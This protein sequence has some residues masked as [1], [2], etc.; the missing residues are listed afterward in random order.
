MGRALCAC[1]KYLWI[2]CLLVAG[3]PI[4]AGTQ[5]SEF[6]VNTRYI[7]ENILVAGAGWTADLVASG[8]DEHISSGIR[9]DMSALI[10][11]KLNTA[12]L[13]D[14]AKRLRREFRARTVDRH[15]MRGKTPDT[16]EVVFD[17]KL[18]PARFDVSVPKFAYNSNQGWNGASEATATV[19]HNSFTAGLLSDGDDL[20]ERDT[21]IEARYENSHLGSDNVRFKFEFDDFH[22]LWNP[23]TAAL[24][25]AAI[26]R[27]RE[28]FEP[29]L[30]LAVARPLTVSFG[31]SFERMQ[32]EGPVARVEAANA[33]IAS[34]RLHNRIEDSDNLQEFDAGYDL[35]SG[36]RSLASDYG[37]NRHHF[38][39]RYTWTHGKQ[40]VI[41]D[42]MG[43][44]ITGNA[45]LY[46]VF[47]L[48]NSN[49]LRGWNKYEL[50]PLGG[51]RVLSNS[52]EYRY[53]AFQ[54][55]YDMGTIWSSGEAVVARKSVGF[56]VREGPFSVAVA[57]PLKEGRIDPVLM[58]SM[59]Y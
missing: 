7:V 37:Y 59:N 26:Y 31:V 8:R 13:D 42:A 29:V 40:M 5:D 33:F 54:A 16:V 2:G 57:F 32:D 34:V 19:N 47:A 15:V 30:T 55:F 56:G 9:K 41:D 20:L 27:T 28:N 36:M 53:G 3:C 25:G 35:R 58:V 44:I 23:Q 22:N 1:M 4:F 21:G 50:D 12:A 52:V 48:G 43:G 45:P 6:N 38:Q 17:I 49:I 46:D 24:D 18:R 11:Q 14:L 39:F 51:N 10:G